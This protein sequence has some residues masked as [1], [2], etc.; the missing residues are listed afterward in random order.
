MK[1]TL[2]N[3]G[4]AVT[5]LIDFKNSDHNIYTK[6]GRQVVID[7]ALQTIRTIQKRV[8]DKIEEK[9]RP[10]NLKSKKMKYKSQLKDVEI[11]AGRIREII[12]NHDLF[13]SLFSLQG[14][15]YRQPLCYAD[16]TKIDCNKKYTGRA[17]EF[18]E[19]AAV[20]AGETSINQSEEE[21][22][23][24]E[25]ARISYNAVKSDENNIV[26]DPKVIEKAKNIVLKD[27][28]VKY[29]ATKLL[30]K[31]VTARKE[32]VEKIKNTCGG[33]INFNYDEA[34]KVQNSKEN[35]PFKTSSFNIKQYIEDLLDK[36]NYNYE[37]VKIHIT[38]EFNDLINNKLKSENFYYGN[39]ILY[40]SRQFVIDKAVTSLKSLKSK[41]IAELEESEDSI[42]QKLCKVRCEALEE[43]YRARIISVD[44]F[45]PFFNADISQPLKIRNL[46]NSIVCDIFNKDID[47]IRSVLIAEASKSEKLSAE[48]KDKSVLYIKKEFNRKTHLLYQDIDI[49][50]INQKYVKYFTD[51]Y[52]KPFKNISRS[53]EC[54]RSL[55]QAQ[56]AVFNSSKGNIN[57]ILASAKLA[58]KGRL[59]GIAEVIEACSLDGEFLLNTE[60]GFFGFFE[61]DKSFMSKI[62]NLNTSMCSSLKVSI[63]AG[64]LM[65]LSKVNIQNS[66]NLSYE[67][68]KAEVVNGAVIALNGIVEKMKALTR[69][70]VSKKVNSMEQTILSN[71]EKMMLENGLKM[72][73]RNKIVQD[74]LLRHIF[75]T[76]GRVNDELDNFIEVPGTPLKF[77]K[78]LSKPLG[79]GLNK[80]FVN[81]KDNLI[82]KCALNGI[83]ENLSSARDI[84]GGLDTSRE[85][86][87]VFHTSSQNVLSD[88]DSPDIKSKNILFN[89][90]RIVFERNSKE[91]N[92]YENMKLLIK[93]AANGAKGRAKGRACI[94][95]IFNE[96]KC[97]GQAFLTIG[98]DDV[99]VET[100]KA[101]FAGEFETLD[102]QSFV[103]DFAG[104]KRIVEQVSKKINLILQNL[105][106]RINVSNNIQELDDHI[107]MLTIGEYKVIKQAIHKLEK[108]K[109]ELIQQLDIHQY[110][111]K[112]ASNN[113]N[114]YRQS[115]FKSNLNKNKFN[116]TGNICADT[117]HSLIQ[118]KSNIKHIK[119]KSGLIKRGAISR[120]NV[121]PNLFNNGLAYKQK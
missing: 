63:I 93:L 100:K 114:I 70:N 38:Q 60:N 106:N 96:Q 92:K 67:I 88:K 51:E 115:G 19:V 9:E 55:M 66:R 36:N 97:M 59:D 109:Q 82:D 23:D 39:D 30:S 94:Q 110:K 47:H 11:A 31:A 75:K 5:A 33:F 53:S 41:V 29:V 10:D 61:P 54:K 45:K 86:D 1:T 46:D 49:S 37:A 4:K 56:N 81:Q 62:N 108:L 57:T 102:I 78:A 103:K 99:S 16:G 35:N 77:N 80:M 119:H 64:Q 98:N 90:R 22:L 3:I 43:V 84:L 104:R 71:D 32:A 117:G 27:E 83:V 6:H 111:N 73:W 25:F 89:A 85:I 50:E 17:E 21:L 40:K 107:Y 58:L 121:Q 87:N 95:K 34:V 20:F 44:I 42:R 105:Y 76:T 112:N 113:R 15:D 118:S 13:G 68:S 24:K 28:S 26:L 74:Q 116:S 91:H 65:V 72:Y 14:Q 69:E 101:A 52:Q 12:K 120:I 7:N 8:N 18:F 79:Y 48:F 2:E